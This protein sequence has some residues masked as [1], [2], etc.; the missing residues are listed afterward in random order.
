[1]LTIKSTVNHINKDILMSMNLLIDLEVTVHI[2]A[3]QR[4]FTQFST[5][6]FYYQTKLD[7]ILE[8]SKRDTICIDFNINDKFLCLNLTDC[9]YAS[10]LYY[11]LI[12]TS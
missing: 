7:K 9:V 4:M 6:I 8:S 3:N 10:D 1:M 11:N 5:K 2:I 12:S